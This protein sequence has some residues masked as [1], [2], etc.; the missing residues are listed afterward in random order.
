MANIFK[1]GN[2]NTSQTIVNDI[3]NIKSYELKAEIEIK[4]NKNENN[5][6]IKQ[7]YISPEYNSQEVIE[8]ENVKGVI[9]ERE[10]NN[11]KIQNTKLNLTTMFNNY[12]Y[13]SENVLDLSSFIQKCKNEDY[14]QKENSNEITLEKTVVPVKEH[15]Y[16]NGICTV[17]GD[18]DPNYVPPVDPQKP[19]KGTN[20]AT[21][22]DSNMLPIIA[23]MTLAAAGVAG[24]VIDVIVPV[25]STVML[26]WKV[27]VNT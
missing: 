18:K 3:L 7:K 11:L 17:C 5:Y 13:L 4:S 1:T 9:I 26:I 20:A 12:E 25:L 24:T 8:P 14:K 19:Q 2:N 23:L 10:G 16:E 6:I 27:D 15:N 22:D 21:G